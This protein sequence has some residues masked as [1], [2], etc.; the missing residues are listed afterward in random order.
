MENL[1]HVLVVDDDSRLRDLLRRYLTDNGFLVTTAPDAGAARAQLRLFQFD[2]LVLDVMMPGESG[3]QLAGS[4]RTTGQVPILMLTARGETEDRIAGLEAG[5]DDYVPK[6]FEPRELLLRAT[7]ILRRAPKPVEAAQ[8]VQLGR[9][10]FHPD[11]AELESADSTVRLTEV[12]ASLLKVLAQA[13][14]AIVSRE[15][16]AERSALPV[17]ARSVDV[18]VT[19]L[20][21]KI[22]DDPKLPRYLQ[23]VRG[24]GYV[25]RPD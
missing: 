16:L 21:R 12:E 4:I 2:L 7:A 23:T 11:R 24:S 17:N 3:L 19:R 20:R 13:P 18:Q 10:R 5:V 6:P 1:P 15:D 22:E 9:W 14:H 25:L 8:A